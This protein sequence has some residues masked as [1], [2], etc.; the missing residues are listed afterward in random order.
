M[1]RIPF[2]SYAFGKLMLTGEYAVTHGARA[3]ALPTRY[4][5]QLKATPLPYSE[6]LI[7][8]ARD[9]DGQI[10]LSVTFEGKELIPSESTAEADTLIKLLKKAQE[11]NPAFKYTGYQVE[12]LLEFSRHWGLGSSST[13]VALL[14]QW[15]QCDAFELFFSTLSGSGYDVAVS[16]HGKPLLFK[17]RKPKPEVQLLEYTMPD[18]DSLC[19]LYL[20]KK[21]S[22]QA[23]LSR[24]ASVQIDPVLIDDVDTI[25]IE[26]SRVNTSA[27]FDYLLEQHEGLISRLIGLPTIKQSL[28]KNYPLLIKSLGAWG[29]DFALVRISSA[30]DLQYF[31]NKGYDTIV[32]AREM[33]RH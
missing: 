20:G 14:A 23:E 22:S 12:T 2:E 9:A 19:F 21:Q 29:G 27:D 33:I 6:K 15:S 24:T 4:G 10:W 17:L 26:L 18:V 5:Q 30:S 1:E 25:S 13:L 31:K 3:L 28:F 8:Q 32:P 16:L 11:L 7:W